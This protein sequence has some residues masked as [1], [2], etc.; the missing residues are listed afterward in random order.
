MLDAESDTQIVN[1]GVD[2]SFDGSTMSGVSGCNQYN[3]PYEATGNEISF[4]E[5]AGT[6]MACPEDEM[7][8]EDRYLQLLAG[9]AAYEVDGSSMSMSDAEGTPVLQFSRG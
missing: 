7:A 1:V 4:G 2:A 6:L 9:V 3:A 8:V 5:I